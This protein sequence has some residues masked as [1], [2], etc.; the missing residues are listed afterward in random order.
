M[1]PRAEIAAAVL[2]VTMGMLFL[3]H[4]VLRLTVITWPVAEQ[5]FMSL[6]LPRFM[7]HAVTITEAAV[8]L[9]LIIGMHVRKAALVGAV[10]LSSATVLVHAQNGF[11][12]SNAGGGWE[13]PAFWVVALICQS[14][15][16]PGGWAL[17][18]GAKSESPSAATGARCLPKE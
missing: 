4:V 1:P 7:A 5:F 14:L 3:T 13:Y 18:F 11:L 2:R 16:G 8:G 17:V 10:I 9:L 12:F 15:L 6:G